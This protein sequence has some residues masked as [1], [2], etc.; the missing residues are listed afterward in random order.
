LARRVGRHIYEQAVVKAK[1]ERISLRGISKHLFGIV[2]L[3]A[4]S[5]SLP[6][7]RAIS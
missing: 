5:I 6:P 7:E 3:E 1:R 2:R 4:A